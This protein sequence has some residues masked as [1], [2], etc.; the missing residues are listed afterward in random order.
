[1]PTVYTHILAVKYP[2]T[3]DRLIYNNNTVTKK[4]TVNNNKLIKSAILDLLFNIDKNQ[5]DYNYCL[6]KF[7]NNLYI[8]EPKDVQNN[9]YTRTIINYHPLSH[10]LD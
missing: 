8:I 3:A 1:M 5:T 9:T 6:L 10:Y 2:T 4:I 7:D